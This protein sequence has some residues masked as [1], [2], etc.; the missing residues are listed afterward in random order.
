MCPLFVHWTCIFNDHKGITTQQK[1][2]VK[3]TMM[4]VVKL[5]F[6]NPE[7]GPICSWPWLSVE[8]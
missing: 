8:F 4:F 5:E 3:E 7:R 1:S 2:H 6:K